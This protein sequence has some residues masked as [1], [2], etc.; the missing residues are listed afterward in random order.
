M[1]SSFQQGLGAAD[2]GGGES[3]VKIS[4][5]RTQLGYCSRFSTF[6]AATPA[7]SVTSPFQYGVGAADNDGGES[8][9]ILNHTTEKL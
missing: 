2:N 5:T 4:N 1:T 8:F 6:L 9:E 7:P 3:L